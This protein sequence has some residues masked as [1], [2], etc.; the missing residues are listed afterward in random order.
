MIRLSPSGVR[1]YF[2]RIPTTDLY[3]LNPLAELRRQGVRLPAAPLPLAKRL[4]GRPDRRDRALRTGE[5]HRS[6]AKRAGA[7]RIVYIVDDDFV[8]GA[9]DP[10]LPNTTG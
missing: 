2:D 9:A 1:E 8:A 4:S 3:F 5:R 6:P 10:S 7:K